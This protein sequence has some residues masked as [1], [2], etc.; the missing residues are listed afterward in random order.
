[1]D[2]SCGKQE[3]LIPQILPPPMNQLMTENHFHLLRGVVLMGQIDG[4]AE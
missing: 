3:Q 2:A 4:C 1:M